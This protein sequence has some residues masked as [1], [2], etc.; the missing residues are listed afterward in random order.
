MSM[1]WLADPATNPVADDPALVR[2]TV[3]VVPVGAEDA[4]MASPPDSPNDMPTDPDTGAGLTTRM[5]ASHTLPSERYVP[6]VGNANTDFGSVGRTISQVGQA[7]QRELAGEWGHG[8]MQ[9]TEGISP[10]IIDGTDLGDTYFAANRQPINA[11]AGDYMSPTG[12][13]DPAFEAALAYTGAT[14]TR[15]AAAASVYAMFNQGVTG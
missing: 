8:S 12:G 3:D 6:D 4:M 14:R 10:T 2:S 13:G 7:P 15:D 1:F 11:D 9:I 5:L